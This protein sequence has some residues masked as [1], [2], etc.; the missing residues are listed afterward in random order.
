MDWRLFLEDYFTF[1]QI[2]K[3][4]QPNT[5]K[6]YRSDCKV[7]ED[8]GLQNQKNPSQLSHQELLILM[9]QLQKIGLHP[10]SQARMLSAW[11]GFFD[12][13]TFTQKPHLDPL[14]FF[15]QPKLPRY[16]PVVLAVHEID[17]LFLTQDQSTKEG[18]RNFLIFQLL[19]AC[20]LRISELL[21]LSIADLDL[22]GGF[23]HV[24]GKGNK[25]RFVP[26]SQKMAHLLK[27]YIENERF[28]F[29]IQPGFEHFVF[30]NRF[31]KSLSR[32][33][34]FTILQEAVKK[35]G[36]NKKISP[37]TFR[38]SFATHL[39]EAG[40]D[41]RIVQQLL[42]HQS[43]TTTAIYTHLDKDFLQTELELYHPLAKKN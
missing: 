36:W 15:P 4:L 31:G 16:L 21:A 3:G 13:L 10:A 39:I 20:G 9:D 41:L 8:F 14:A 33:M 35:L 37:H 6:A 28:L 1:L 40:A 18:L 22:K 29:P 24:L 5:L 30:L 27:N 12:F 17:Q 26:M 32:I 7:L 2:E 42:G 11:R 38:H 43:I 19:Y 25:E 34:V 23:V